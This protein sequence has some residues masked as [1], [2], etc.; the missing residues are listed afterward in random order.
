[1][2]FTLGLNGSEKNTPKNSKIAAWWD[3]GHYISSISER[4]TYIDNSTLDYQRISLIANILLCDEQKA[5]NMLKTLD[6]D[7]ILV[8]YGSQY[9]DD[10]DL[11]KINWICKIA[12]AYYSF[13]N[14]YPE[15]SLADTLLYRLSHN[16]TR[17]KRGLLF[18]RIL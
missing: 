14:K 8:V 7:Y 17:K 10:D 15:I 3:H 16:T 12:N 9:T 1:M 5:F 11:H 2:T 18:Q 13:H 4:K 6:A